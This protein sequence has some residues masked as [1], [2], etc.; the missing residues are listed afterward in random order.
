VRLDVGRLAANNKNRHVV[1]FL[2]ELINSGA[3]FYVL[4]FLMGYIVEDAVVY[5]DS[6]LFLEIDFTQKLDGQYRKGQHLLV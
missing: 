4:F 5:I 1:L 6:F 3:D 2:S